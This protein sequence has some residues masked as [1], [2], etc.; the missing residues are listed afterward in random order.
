MSTAFS[1][2]TIDY[3]LLEAADWLWSGGAFLPSPL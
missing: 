3:Y 1:A 2:P